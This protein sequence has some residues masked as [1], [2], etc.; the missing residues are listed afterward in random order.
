MKILTYTCE[1][2]GCRYQETIKTNNNDIYATPKC[3]K[4]NKNM[5]LVSEIDFQN[6]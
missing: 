6:E 1:T 5:K 4:C 2:K 3:P